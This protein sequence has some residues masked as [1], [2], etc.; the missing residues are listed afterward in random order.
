M[1][2]CG[3]RVQNLSLSLSFSLLGERDKFSSSNFSKDG[4]Y[5]ADFR[6][7]PRGAKP[8]ISRA[9]F[10]HRTLDIARREYTHR[11]RV[12][13]IESTTETKYSGQRE[14]AVLSRRRSG[15]ENEKRGRKKK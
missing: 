10:R 4:I 3:G 12:C 6:R 2:L 14:K 7:R 1:F 5:W 11:R 13:G 15:G 9:L 8:S